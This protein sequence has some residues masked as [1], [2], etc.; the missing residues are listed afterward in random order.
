MHGSI[1]SNMQ[2]FRPDSLL[3]LT[4]AGGAWLF[5]VRETLAVILFYVRRK[6]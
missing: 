5:E 2:H 6:S 4:N 3:V 1:G